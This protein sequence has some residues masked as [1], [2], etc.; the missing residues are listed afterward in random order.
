MNQVVVYEARST[1]RTILSFPEAC[2]KRFSGDLAT[3]TSADSHLLA[4]LRVPYLLWLRCVYGYCHT[5]HR[6]NKSGIGGTMVGA[7]NAHG[8]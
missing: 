7:G 2:L 8:A 5:L 3:S 4:A 1:G 6:Y